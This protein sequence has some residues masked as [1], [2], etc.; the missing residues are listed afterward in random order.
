MQWVAVFVLLSFGSV[1]EGGNFLPYPVMPEYQTAS[2]KG[3]SLYMTEVGSWPF[4]RSYA[5]T[6]DSERN[7]VF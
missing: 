5:V 1:H 7:I 4:G 6:V 2:T 3:D